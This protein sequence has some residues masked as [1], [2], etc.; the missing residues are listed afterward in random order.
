METMLFILFGVVGFLY[1]LFM[2]VV[3]YKTQGWF[4]VIVGILIIIIYVLIMFSA[5]DRFSVLVNS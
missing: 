1:C 2:T 4:G 3:S 5:I